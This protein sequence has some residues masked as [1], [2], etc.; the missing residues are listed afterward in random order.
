MSVNDCRKVLFG[1]KV[2]P[3]YDQYWCVVMESRLITEC[4]QWK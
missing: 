3:V 4:P 1:V 2:S